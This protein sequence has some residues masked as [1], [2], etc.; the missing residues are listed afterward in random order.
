M[1]LCNYEIQPE[2]KQIIIW[3]CGRYESLLSP[4]LAVGISGEDALGDRVVYL[5]FSGE[6]LHNIYPLDF[7]VWTFPFL[8]LV[9]SLTI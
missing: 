5:I 4:D 7:I 2:V 8:C 9:L 3:L 1:L 6:P